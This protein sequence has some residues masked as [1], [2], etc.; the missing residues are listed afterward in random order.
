MP[1][2]CANHRD[3][4]KLLREPLVAVLARYNSTLA[5]LFA[6]LQAVLERQGRV[7]VP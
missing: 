5:G 2:S 4:F 1:S 6:S 3:H 7:D